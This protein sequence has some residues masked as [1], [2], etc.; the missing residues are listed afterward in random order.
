MEKDREQGMSEGPVFQSGQHRVRPLLTI[1][2][3]S[4]GERGFLSCL[5]EPGNAKS[6][7][8]SVPRKASDPPNGGGGGARIAPYLACDQE[9]TGQ[10]TLLV[11]CDPGAV[12]PLPRASVS[13]LRKKGVVGKETMRPIKTSLIAL[14]WVGI[15]QIFTSHS[16]RQPPPQGHTLPRVCCQEA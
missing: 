1:V 3:P 11:L 14:L 10:G 7:P 5:F 15:F 8:T 2:S 4:S 9:G 16:P 12:L 6:H 13:T